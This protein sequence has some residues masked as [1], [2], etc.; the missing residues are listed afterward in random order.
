MIKKIHKSLAEWRKI[1]SKDVFEIT[2]GNGTEPAFNNAYWDNKKEGLY[3]CSNC[4]LTLFSSEHKFDSGTGWP[5]Y[6]KPFRQAHVIIHIDRS[7][8]MVRE[9]ARCAR[10]D[11]HLGHVFNDGPRPT[12]LRY[13]MN[14][15]ALIFE[16]K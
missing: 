1:L 10:C 5:S 2:R 14:S 13:C 16:E 9:E 15:A 11:S 3:L 12:G 8:G 6:W 4:G 7:G